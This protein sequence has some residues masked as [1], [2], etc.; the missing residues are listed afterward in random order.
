M[1]AGNDDVVHS[2][3]TFELIGH[4]QEPGKIAVHVRE[5]TNP[6]GLLHHFAPAPLCPPSGT[7][8]A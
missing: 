8:V 6:H 7:T 2:P 5:E 3:L 1:I 4:R